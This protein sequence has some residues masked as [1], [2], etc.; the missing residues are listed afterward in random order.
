MNP[1]NT[2][3]KSRDSTAEPKPSALVLAM[4][5]TAGRRF[6]REA[7]A[8][9]APLGQILLFTGVRYERMPDVQVEPAVPQRKRS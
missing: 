7:P 4:P 9:A 1:R 8:D 5:S 3:S 6:R 2:L